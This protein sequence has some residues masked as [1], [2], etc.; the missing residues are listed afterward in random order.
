MGSQTVARR[1]TAPSRASPPAAATA[2]RALLPH[3]NA[4]PLTHTHTHTQHT[5]PLEVYDRSGRSSPVRYR[6]HPSSCTASPVPGPVPDPA[7]PPHS[8][9]AVG[10]QLTGTPLARSCR[11]G[12]A[13]GR[14]AAQRAVC[15]C[16][17]VSVCV[18]VCAR[19]RLRCVVVGGSGEG[20]P[21]AGRRR[22]RVARRLQRVF[23]A[24]EAAAAC[25]AAP[26]PA[27]WAPLSSRSNTTPPPHLKCLSFSCVTR[28]PAP[29]SRFISQ[30]RPCTGKGQ[31]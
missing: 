9:Q 31:W 28:S 23:A 7:P 26:C 10:A 16:L 20:R 21:K 4:A 12:H 30:V 29:A 3:Q 15:V 13:G 18:C 5:D 25:G 1:P 6:T 27:L 17:C 19:A 14:M 24:R 22:G 2:N 11:G 8:P